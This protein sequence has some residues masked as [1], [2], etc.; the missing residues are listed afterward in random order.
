M[1]SRL[2]TA[3]AQLNSERNLSG[4]LREI[5][6]FPIL[7][8][9]EELKLAR[10]WSDRHDLEAVDKLVTS[11]LRL[12]VKI[13]LGYRGYGLPALELIGEGNVGMMWAVKRFDPDRGCRLAAYAMWWI[14]AA[15][16]D[17]VLRSWS[18]VRIGTTSSQKKLFF[19]LRRLKSRMRATEGGDLTCE[20]VNEISRTLNVSE[21]DVI[22]MN[23]RLTG[24]DSSLNAPVSSDSSDEWQNWLVDESPSQE[25]DVANREELA[26]RR[27]R[28]PN[29]LK[30]LSQRECLILTER[31][32]RDDPPTLE[33]LS[34]RYRI[35]PERVRQIEVRAF[36]KL[37]KAMKAPVTAQRT[38]V[39]Y[40]DCS[41]NP[42][43]R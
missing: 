17:Y 35:S 34:R 26:G 13:A 19:N 20:Q 10:R 3:Y 39:A 9:E 2:G 5:H 37:Q 24:P 16:Q 32:L 33:N 36:V 38:L 28:L 30:A 43:R 40:S 42:M 18:L 25:I 29:A 11:H 41:E 27:A 6:R 12:V 14:R 22:T 23:W 21:Q 31:R 1:R 8:A 15:I 7:S 4:Y